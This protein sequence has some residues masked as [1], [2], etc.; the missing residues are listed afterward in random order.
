MSTIGG[1]TAYAALSRPTLGVLGVADTAIA[2]ILD[3][4]LFGVPE[5]TGIHNRYHFVA[6]MRE[7]LERGGVG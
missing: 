3:H 1:S 6:E 4:R 5:V 2:H 7:A